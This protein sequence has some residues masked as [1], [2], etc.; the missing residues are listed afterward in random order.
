MQNRLEALL[1]FHVQDPTDVFNMYAI[2]LEYF[3]Q[4]N[5]SNAE[6]YF[7]LLLE[8]DKNYIPAYMQC[9]I[10]KSNL[11]Q[12]E[13]AKE[14]F[15]IGIAKAKEQKDFHSAQEMEELLNGL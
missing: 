15:T 13:E 4:K 10:M 14:L 8:I 6:K 2:A 5:Y 12:V 7:K 11:S 9:G 1:K 3:S